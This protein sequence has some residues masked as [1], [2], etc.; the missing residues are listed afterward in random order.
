MYSYVIV[1]TT[2]GFS[3]QAM[4]LKPPWSGS[5]SHGGA[6]RV[7]PEAAAELKAHPESKFHM[8]CLVVR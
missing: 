5:E 2:T 4:G 3:G 6:H 7:A 1:D 8:Y